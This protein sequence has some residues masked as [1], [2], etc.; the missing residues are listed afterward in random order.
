MEAQKVEKKETRK[1][2]QA[3]LTDLNEEYRQLGPEA[4]AGSGGA[5]QRRGEISRELRKVSTQ[6]Y[7]KEPDVEVTLP[8]SATGHPFRINE[9]VF[10]AGKYTVKKSEA[11]YLLWMV[12]R[13][14]EDEL[15]RL[16]ANG[17][18]VDLGAIGDKAKQL[19]DREF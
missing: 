8:R 17:E 14:R 6:L 2:L 9:K 16:R 1:E 10:F 12:D 4:I 11:Q 18:H 5:I 13:N 19:D 15:N 7:V 3:K